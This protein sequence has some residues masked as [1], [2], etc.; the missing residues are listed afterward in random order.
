M[1]IQTIQGRV[2][3]P[4]R[5]Q[6]QHE[7]WARD[8]KP[9][10]TGVLGSTWGITADGIG[11]VAA[12]FE[13]EAAAKTNNTRPEQGAWWEETAPAFE[14]VTFRDCTEVDTVLAGPST[15][16][17]FVQ[18]IEGRVKDRE[19]ARALLRDSESQLAVGRPDILGGLMAW[20]GDDGAFTQVMYFR[21]EAEARAAESTDTDAEVDE[22]YQAM[23]AV[24]PTF[25]DLTEP[26]IE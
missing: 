17:G 21:S 5:F 14:D 7:T 18:V 23:M 9:G 8:L 11:F 24:E 13:S 12:R 10:A 26:H 20:H 22:Q 25:L 15:D 19:A 16:A 2:K 1:F 6:R 3:D 4:D